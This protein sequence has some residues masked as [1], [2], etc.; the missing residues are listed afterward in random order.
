MGYSLHNSDETDRALVCFV[1][2]LSIRRFQLGEDSMEVGDTLNM[3]GFL[4]AKRGELDDALTLL[5]DALKIRKLQEDH[6]KVSETLKN[7]G[8]IHRE[9]EESELALECYEECLRIRRL[10]LGPQHEKVADVLIAMGN[11]HSENPLQ[12]EE[13]K[14]SYQEALDIRKQVFGEHDESVAIVLQHMGTIEFRAN[15][16]DRARDLLSEFIRIRRDNGTH[17]DG[18]YVNVLFMVGNIHKTEGNEAEAKLYWNEAYQVFQEGDLS[19]TNPQLAEAMKHLVEEDK[20][21]EHDTNSD[22]Q[23]KKSL[24]GI[25]TERFKKDKSEDILFQNGRKSIRRKGKGLK[26]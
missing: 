3:M 1:E 16:Y 22:L 4:K 23:G 17:N 9:K 10:E 19:G 7:I 13:A 20:I 11:V 14:Q 8:N 24:F 5:W 2:A 25:V 15:N 6:I 21:D 18:D 26:L 12:A